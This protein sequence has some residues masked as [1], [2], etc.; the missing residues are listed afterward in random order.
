MNT[1]ELPP[2]DLTTPARKC[3]KGPLR[4]RDAVLLLV[5]LV[6]LEVACLV[7][8]FV[9]HALTGMTKPTDSQTAMYGVAASV[10]AMVTVVR[11]GVLRSRLPWPDVMPL[12]TF[13]PL[14]LVSLLPAAWGLSI[15]GSEVGE[16]DPGAGAGTRVLP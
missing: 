5:R 9:L 6:V 14:V 15:L 10:L 12:R 16:P 7:A 8:L 4:L 2:R 1:P 3:P 11:L 13:H